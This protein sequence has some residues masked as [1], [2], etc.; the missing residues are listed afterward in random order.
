M[1]IVYSRCD[2]QLSYNS[3]GEW[4][5]KSRLLLN[6]RRYDNA[7]APSA[8][9]FSVADPVAN[10]FG[11]SVIAVNVVF[12]CAFFIIQPFGCTVIDKVELSPA[13]SRPMNCEFGI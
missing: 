11:P 2:D 12:V 10:S 9:Y 5:V 4:Y 6:S 7:G 3:I 8:N 1:A 13:C